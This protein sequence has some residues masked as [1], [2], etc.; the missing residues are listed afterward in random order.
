MAPLESVQDMARDTSVEEPALLASAEDMARERVPLVRETCD[1]SEKVTVPGKSVETLGR[2]LVLRFGS[3]I[4]GLV[5]KETSGRGR[6]KN[7]ETGDDEDWIPRET[8]DKEP[9]PSGIKGS[10]PEEGAE[11]NPTDAVE[12]GTVTGGISSFALSKGTIGTETE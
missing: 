12:R 3:K 2:A 5:R 9:I 7:E 4:E 6:F 11:V 10:G 1:A 8:E